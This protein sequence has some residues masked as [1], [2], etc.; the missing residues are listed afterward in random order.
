[1]GVGKRKSTK[2]LTQHE[3]HRVIKSQKSTEYLK[4]IECQIQRVIVAYGQK[5]S[6]YLLK[7]PQF[8][9]KAN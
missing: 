1:M 6:L 7:R 9:G 5:S 3:V 8:Y 2:I 4:S